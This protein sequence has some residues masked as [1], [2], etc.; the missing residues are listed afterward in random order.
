M[1]SG[2][3][4]ILRSTQILDPAVISNRTK[5]HDG[6]ESFLADKLG[7]N[8]NRSQVWLCLR[9]LKLLPW[10]S[11]A[12]IAP[13]RISCCCC[14]VH[15]VVKAEFIDGETFSSLIRVT[16]DIEAGT[17]TASGA[18]VS[19]QLIWSV[20]TGAVGDV[21][22]GYGIFQGIESLSRPAVCGNQ[23]CETGEREIYTKNV[24]GSRALVAGV[25][26]SSQNISSFRKRL[27][28]ATLRR[29]VRTVQNAFTVYYLQVA[30]TIASYL[31]RNAL[32]EVPPADLHRVSAALT[33]F[34]VLLLAN[35]IAGLAIQEQIAPYVSRDTSGNTLSLQPRPPTLAAGIVSNL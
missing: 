28:T 32:W 11:L 35:V 30:R 33:A 5:F 24:D 18:V 25:C 7:I 20:L 3:L 13:V 21:V 12:L 8:Q 14:C 6:L 4:K 2:A 29:D 27:P 22:P 26:L 10:I 17:T 16:V 23:F 1:K 15:Q 9:F 31:T 34:A 19:S